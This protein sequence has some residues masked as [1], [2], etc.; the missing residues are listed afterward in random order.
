MRDESFGAYP[1][2]DLIGLFP[3]CNVSAAP[4][5]TDPV[6]SLQLRISMHASSWIA[7]GPS[8]TYRISR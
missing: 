1:F 2:L 6:R 3:A 5:G 7:L 8:G 4:I